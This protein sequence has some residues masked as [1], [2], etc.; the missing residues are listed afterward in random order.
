VTI[1]KRFALI[2]KDGDWRYPY[3]KSERRSE[4]YGFAIGGDR[5]GKAEYTTDLHR[6][7]QAV[8]LEGLG[9]RAKTEERGKGK[10][11]DTVGLGRSAIKSYWLDSEFFPLIKD[12]KLKP[13][14]YADEADVEHPVRGAGLERLALLTAADY[15]AAIE[16]LEDRW[17]DAQ[18]KMLVGHASSEIHTLSM[19]DIARLA[20]YES[21]EA[22][23]VQYGRLGRLFADH[24]GI[25]GLENSTQALAQAAPRD[26]AGRWRWRVRP[27]LVDALLQLGL[28]EDKP[29]GLGRGNAARE[30]DA[31][32]KT[33][34]TSET[35]RQA[36][37]NARIGQGG[38]RRRMLRIWEGQCALSGCA[39]ESV[40]VASHAKAWSESSNEER[41]DAYNGLLLAASLDRLFDKGL[42]SFSEDG[43]L[44]VSEVLT[45]GDLAKLGLLRSARLR[46]LRP[47]HLPYLSEHRRSHGFEK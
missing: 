38:Y 1:D 46:R 7:I 33:A 22:A 36:L 35:T 30:V 13:I 47:R 19:D 12:A 6:V 28:I 29:A 20:D 43:A 18:R 32:P 3:L 40:L 42:I 37:I 45:D 41:L 10:D 31:D 23:N 8:V 2:D 21:F 4:R 34:G 39:I 16:E 26:S 27:A 15:V 24:F 14:N 44:L 11:G 5:F 25:E 9:V 17:S